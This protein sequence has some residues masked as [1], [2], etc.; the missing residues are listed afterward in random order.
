MI[1]AVVK[2]ALLRY[3]MEVVGI[4]D[5]FGG[6]I[7]REAVPLNLEAV[8]GILPRGGTILGTTNRDNPF[9]HPVRPGAAEYEDVSDACIEFLRNHLGVDALLVIGGDGSLRCANDFARK[10][11]AVIGIPKTID[12]DLAATDFTFGFD[13]AVNTATEA[14]D[15]L[16][17][18]AESH[19]RV[20]VLEVMGR[21]GGWI[22]LY[23]GI[24]GGA[25][26]ILIPEI[27]FSYEAVCQKIRD[28]VAGGKQFSIV[29]VAEGAAPVGG[30]PVVAEKD[31]DRPDPVRLGGIGQ[32]VAGEIARRL[33]IE[34]RV[35]V[36]GHLQRGGSPTPADRLLAT[37]YGVAAVELAARGEFG[38]MV[39]LQGTRIVSV[40]LESGVAVRK[41]VDPA[42]ALVRAARAVGISFGSPDEVREGEGGAEP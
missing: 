42:G 34:T 23:A 22:A 8:S 24:A 31:P 11:L 38:R 1:R 2:A 27:P 26:V 33:R 10:G 18:T 15:R 12:N 41:L 30:Q 6:L 29:V 20:M 16:H 7:R 28:R 4:R 5:G 35:T 9:R 13:T 40:P 37:R 17:T 14:V 3:G 19:H 39:A 32:V 36:L 25:D 21:Y